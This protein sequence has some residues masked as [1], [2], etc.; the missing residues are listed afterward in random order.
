VGSAVNSF[1]IRHVGSPSVRIAEARI[2]L[3]LSID[4]AKEFKPFGDID[5]SRDLV[6]EEQNY[7][8]VCAALRS[9]THVCRL[10][11]RL[12]RRLPHG[13]LLTP[14]PRSA[15]KKAPRVRGFSP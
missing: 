9:S 1:S 8:L 7:P 4:Y 12:P 11:R 14:G 6:L 3:C 13:M 15:T 2:A 10:P 5:R